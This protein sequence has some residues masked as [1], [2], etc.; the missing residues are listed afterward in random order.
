MKGTTLKLIFVALIT[1]VATAIALP[2]F[3]SVQG[4][5]TGGTG[6]TGDAIPPTCPAGTTL[7]NGVCVQLS[8]VVCAT[9]DTTVSFG[10]VDRENQSTNP[11]VNAYP[12]VGGSEKSAI[13]NINAGGSFTASPFDNITVVFNEDAANNAAG[14]GDYYME[15]V[16]FTDPCKGT[17]VLPGTDAASSFKGLA[18]EG[19]MSVTIWNKNETSVLAPGTDQALANGESV[20]LRARIDGN[21]IDAFY[22]APGCDLGLLAVVDYN[23]T[24]VKKIEPQGISWSNGVVP[25]SYTAIR[26]RQVAYLL[27]LSA[28]NPSRMKASIKE[29]DSV[30][31]KWYIEAETSAS[32][33]VAN[34]AL[35][36]ANITYFD[37]AGYKDKEL[38]WIY[39]FENNDTPANIGA[40]NISA[41][42]YLG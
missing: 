32:P 5:D 18:R 4:G 35:D 16:S 17:V 40:Q 24:V 15:K 28:L 31:F 13:A 25:T 20:A 8:G 7:Q 22:G 3:M 2:F 26:G 9:E 11:D 37:C 38:A 19:G 14:S 10:V 23:N 39:A 41:P 33:Q 30:N 6:G 29:Y 21:T 42:L 27:D 1:V 36:D 34:N 12:I